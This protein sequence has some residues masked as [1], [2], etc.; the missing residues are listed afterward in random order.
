[1]DY[2][3]ERSEWEKQDRH[4]SSLDEQPFRRRF[5]FIPTLPGLYIVRG[6]RQIGKSSWLK[7][8]L[9]HHSKTSKCLYLSCENVQDHKELAEIL[10]S[11]RHCQVVLLDEVN[12]VKEWDRAVKHEIDT[13]VP[14]I[15]MI[16]GSHAHDLKK[17]ADRMPGRFDAGGEFY[18]LPMLF[19]EFTEVRKQAGWQKSDRVEELRDYFKIGGFPLAVLE[20]GPQSITP[21]IVQET[22]YRWLSG[23]V[24][25]LGKQESYLREIMI[26]IAFSIQTPISFQTLAKKTTIGSHNT[27]QEYISVLESCFAL[28]TLYPVDLNTGSYRLKKN[29]KFYF[30]DPLLFHLAHELSGK[31]VTEDFEPK[32]AELVAHEQLSRSHR[33]FGYFSNQNGE[34]D[35]VLPGEWAVEVKWSDLP[36]NLSRSYLNLGIADKRVWLKRGFLE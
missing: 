27:V 1:M 15:M 29:R 35:F 13:G 17:G 25:R 32:M 22:Y 33:R 21:K 16:T 18:L 36:T 7:T 6:P 9:S 8:V 14:K 34:I 24:V 30:T 20:A 10:K 11:V 5:P 28:K 2:F 12:F 26:Q 19:E 23:D 4:L 31:R 3:W